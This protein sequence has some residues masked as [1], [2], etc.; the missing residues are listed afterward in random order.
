MGIRLT[1]LNWWIPNSIVKK[2]LDEVSV[3]TINALRSLVEVYALTLP[4]QTKKGLASL[5]KTKQEKRTAMAAEHILLVEALVEA[6]GETEAVRVG[7]LAMFEVGKKLG[8]DTRDLLGI[9][10]A[11]HKDLVK[12][13]KVLYKVLDIDVN[14]EWH[15]KDRATLFVRRCSFANEYSR[16]TCEILSAADEG[17]VSGLNPHMSMIFEHRMTEGCDK[18]TAKIEFDNEGGKAELKQLL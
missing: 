14:V 6:L 15:G 1:L 16:V 5:A 9:G 10:H 8:M 4:V 11:T 18:C 7:R 17:V 13:A 2:E 3:L 12:A